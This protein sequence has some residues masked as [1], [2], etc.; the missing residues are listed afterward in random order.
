MIKL[1]NNK[2]LKE[3]HQRNPII[4]NYIYK[5][6]KDKIYTFLIIKTNG[7]TQIADEII[8]DTFHSA[9]ESAPKLKNTS[10][11]QSWL[12]QIA[13]RRLSDYLRNKY[14]EKKYFES[15]DN[16][17]KELISDFCIIDK[18]HEKEKG[19]M[20]NTAYNNLN[21]KYREIIKLKYIEK[22]RVKDI[23]KLMGS[24]T[25]MVNSLLARARV[26]LKKSLHRLL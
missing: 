22:L 14:K 10:N 19:F 11:I 2:F 20:I 17:E 8:C 4:F 21:D 15:I 25:A 9:I 16:N 7:N 5:K 1:S 23:A 3:I 13:S 18:I 24:N 26:S 6:Y 12:L